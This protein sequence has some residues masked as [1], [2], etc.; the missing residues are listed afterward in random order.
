MEIFSMEN[1]E[2]EYFIVITF[3]KKCLLTF[4]CL[5]PDHNPVFPK[6]SM[7]IK[8]VAAR[9]SHQRTSVGQYT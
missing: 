3:R 6:Q 1:E 4:S 8:Q 9:F 5:P 7:S 2:T